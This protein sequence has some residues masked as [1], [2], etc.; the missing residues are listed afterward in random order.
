V[1]FQKVKAGQLPTYNHIRRFVNAM[2]DAKKERFLFA[3]PKKEDLETVSRWEKVLDAVTGLVVKSFSPDDCRVLA[4]VMNGNSA[5]NIQKIDMVITHLNL[6]KKA[7]L[8]NA[9][10]QE[11]ANL[12][13]GGGADAAIPLQVHGL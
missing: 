9:S 1:V 7:L 4:K 8:D 6:I 12:T 2:L 3:V 13:Q 10:R 11:V 5:V